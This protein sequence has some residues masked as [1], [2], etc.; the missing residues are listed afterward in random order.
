[1]TSFLPPVVAVLRGYTAQKCRSDVVAGLT[2]AVMIIP[3]S[4]AYALLAGLP[5]HVGLYAATVP[6]VGYAL[7]GNSRTLAIG[8]TAIDSL[9][10]ASAIGALALTGTE[11]YLELCAALAALV[12]IIQV[13][14]GIFRAGFVVRLLTT[15]VIKGFTSAAAL[16]IA[17]N[18]LKL[19]LGVSYDRSTFLGDILLEVWKRISEINV[20]T[21]LIALMAFVVL[22][23]SK[24]TRKSFPRALFVVV[25]G[26]FAVFYFSLES[27]GVD[28]I[29]RIPSG[30]PQFQLPLLTMEMIWALLPSALMIAVVSFMEAISIGQSLL[31]DDEE[32]PNPNGELIGIG[33]ANGLSGIFQGLPVTAG[34]SRSAVNSEAG[35]ETQLAGLITAGSV[36]LILSFLTPILYWIPKAVLGAII[37]TSA[38]G[39]VDVQIVRTLWR[40]DR[41]GWWVLMGTF[42]ATILGG[43]QQGIAIGV[44]LGLLFS[45]RGRSTSEMEE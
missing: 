9:L 41:W 30:L 5:V 38:L 12:A 26:A 8:P 37:I 32:S 1:M 25:L 17:V 27:S 23:L 40:E 24:R 34:F 10:T 14:L 13:L 19:V 39:L 45:K 28:I 2:T 43:I 11:R 15:P 21:V 16:I 36:A 35:V 22:D 33:A 18:Q 29:G 44:I 42:W 31:R 20:P 6:L 7:L 3:Q 4:M